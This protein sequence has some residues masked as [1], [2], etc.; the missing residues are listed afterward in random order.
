MI[1]YYI[2]PIPIRNIDSCSYDM[3]PLLTFPKELNSTLMRMSCFK[4]V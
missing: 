2:P 1:I 4:I 3:L